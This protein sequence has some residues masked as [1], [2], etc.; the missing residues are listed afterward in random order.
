[1]HPV[2]SITICSLCLT[3]DWQHSPS[4]QWCN[5]RA[6]VQMM[7]IFPRDIL[8][9]CLDTRW[10]RVARLQRHESRATCG[11]KVWADGGPGVCLSIHLWK[12]F[13]YVRGS[14]P[15]RTSS[16]TDPDGFMI[17]NSHFWSSRF[18]VRTKPSE[19]TGKFAHPMD[20]L[21]RPNYEY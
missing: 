4:S 8:A 21:Q 17:Q 3:V 13:K 14:D 18:F 7:F 2:H 19:R 20:N 12:C 5:D 9:Q 1:M 6:D 10:Q 15:L 16:M 11:A